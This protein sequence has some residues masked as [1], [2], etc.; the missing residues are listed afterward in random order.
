MTAHRNVTMTEARRSWNRL[1]K[2]VVDTIIPVTLT[3]FGKPV[4]V[5]APYDPDQHTPEK[6]RPSSILTP[7]VRTR[8]LEMF[9]QY[10]ATHVRLFGSVAT[11]TDQPGSDIDFIAD[12]PD[13][14]TL[15]TMFD[16]QAELEAIMEVSVDVVSDDPW[17]GQLVQ[18]IRD[19]A[20]PFT[21]EE[22]P[23]AA[24][25][26]IDNE[27]RSHQRNEGER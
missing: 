6:A 14:F 5:L 1:I 16:L 10:G 9:E 17:G 8:I 21:P 7:D 13:D 27:S 20:I 4:A 11:G 18:A 24:S 26:E 23:R 3:R 22:T 12:F 19:S 15:L 25:S 2:E